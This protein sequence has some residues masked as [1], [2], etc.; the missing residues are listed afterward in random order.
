MQH[1]AAPAVAFDNSVAR[2]S[3]GRGIDTEHADESVLSARRVRCGHGQQS[4]V[5]AAPL[6]ELYLNDIGPRRKTTNRAYRD[7]SLSWQ[8]TTDIVLRQKQRGAVCAN[9]RLYLRLIDIKV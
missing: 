1:A 5:F 3:R 4:T 8:C 2:G 6:P 9:L 7:G